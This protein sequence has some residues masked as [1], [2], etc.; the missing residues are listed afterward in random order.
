MSH[1]NIVISGQAADGSGALAGWRG[2]G[3]MTR[4]DIVAAIADAGLPADI[5]PRE[6]SYRAQAGQAVRRLDNRGYVVRA[7]ARST[8][9]KLARIAGTRPWDARWTVAATNSATADVGDASGQVVA[10]F[11][12]TG[13]V[14]TGEGDAGLIAEVTEIFNA[15]RDAQTFQAGEV[16]AW[17]SQALCRH[18]GATGYSLGYYVPAS[19]RAHVNALCAALM[20][21]GWGRDWAVPL[22]PVATTDELRIGIVRSLEDDIAAIAAAI[23]GAVNEARTEGRAQMQPGRAGQFLRTLSD[24]EGRLASYSGLCGAERTAP[25]RATLRAMSDE[26]RR[27]CGDTATRGA[28]LEMDEPRVT[29]GRVTEQEMVARDTSAIA[30]VVDALD[31]AITGAVLRA[32]VPAPSTELDDVASES[33]RNARTAAARPPRTNALPP[34]PAPRRV[35]DTYRVPAPPAEEPTEAPRSPL[36][37]PRAPLDMD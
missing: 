14:L 19:S 11:E 17:L 25:A 20:T 29:E 24:V 13:D 27:I 32:S 31:R 22:L 23:A 15:L 34:V 4:G 16:T 30:P 1:K 28:M 36:G 10:T 35:D 6:K 26:L 37:S 8:A 33:A 5:A 12:L 21:R 9:V 18:F 2:Q 3:T 7:A